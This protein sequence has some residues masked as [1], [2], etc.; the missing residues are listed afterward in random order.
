MNQEV[1]V[2]EEKAGMRIDIFLAEAMPEVFSRSRVK[3]LVEE[4]K[5]KVFGQNVT[6]HYKIKKDDRIGI[7][8][9]EKRD[10]Q[11]LLSDQHF[12]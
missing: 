10:Y 12:G 2:A 3:K 5:I 11:R 8:S 6:A 1:I 7:S 4:G 9:E